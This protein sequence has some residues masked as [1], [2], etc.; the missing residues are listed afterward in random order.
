MQTTQQ[1][2]VGV[3][4]PRPRVGADGAVALMAA[5]AA[6]LVWACARVSDLHL[7]VRS[8]SGTTEV[9]VVSVIV[10]TLVVAIAGA[11]LLRVLERR[12]AR[13]L[14]TWTIIAAAVWALSLLGPL[15][16][17]RPA[18][19][20]VLAGLHLIVGAVV[21]LGLRRTRATGTPVA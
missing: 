21:I 9:T 16:A 5:A 17:T 14:R 8:G 3:I 11:G 1:R 15:S 13:G 6:A 10:T 4:S 7:E 2:P 12:T 18:A 19:G 20:L